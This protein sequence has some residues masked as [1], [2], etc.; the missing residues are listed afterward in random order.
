MAPLAEPGAW[1]AE[2]VEFALRP[3]AGAPTRPLAK[4]ASGG[5]LSRVMLAIEV[6]LATQG[7]TAPGTFVFDE[8]D[9]GVGGRAAVEVGRRLADLGRRAQVIV[10]THLA[11][12]AAFADRHLVVTKTSRGGE[13]VVTNSG[14]RAVE[15]TDR[16]RELA[17]MLSGQEDSDLARR[18]AAELLERATVGRYPG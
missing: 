3:H 2:D 5:E 16:L 6:A 15:S 14:V 13:D 8:V 10:V 18:H 12:V 4:G 17:R 11:Q 7:S 1:G 9:A